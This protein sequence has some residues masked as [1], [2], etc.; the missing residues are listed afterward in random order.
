MIP[1]HRNITTNEIFKKPDYRGRHR[2]LPDTGFRN[3]EDLLFLAFERR[4]HS[5][6]GLK[7]L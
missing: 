7:Q 5:D 2:T 4:R 1:S 6:L 3:V